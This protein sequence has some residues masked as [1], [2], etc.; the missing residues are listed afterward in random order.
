MSQLGTDSGDGTGH[1]FNC[2]YR[3]EYLVCKVLKPIGLLASQGMRVAGP[4]FIIGFYYLIWL[5]IEAY[6]FH[7]VMAVVK[8]R[9][10]TPFSLVWTATGCIIGFNVIF[11]HVMAVIVKANGPLE[12]VKIERL[13]YALKQRLG[14]KAIDEDSDRYQGISPE[15]KQILVY[16]TKSVDQLR[17]IWNRY[18]TKCNEVKPARA[19]HCTVCNRCVLMM[20]HHCPW[21]NNCM[22]MEN[23]RYFLLFILYLLVGCAYATMTIVS[24]WN[25][26]IYRE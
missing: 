6:L 19:H 26:K 10:G 20:D 15:V 9:L 18:C 14:R 7:G 5:H 8:Q 3:L 4:G 1:Y 24:I 25:H 13:R 22:G 21:V 2:N 11:N 12:L 17:H 23:Y 16:R